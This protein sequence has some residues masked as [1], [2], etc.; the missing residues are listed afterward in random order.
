MAGTGPPWTWMVG[1]LLTALLLRVTEP[2]L[3][4]AGAACNHAPASGAS[5]GARDLGAGA[6]TREGTPLGTRENDSSSRIINGTDCP[7]HAQPWQAALLLK[8]NQLYCGAV[9]VDRQWLLT[10]AHCR[11]KIFKIRL[12]HRFLSPVYEQGQQ[13]LRGVKSIPHPGFSHPGHTNDLM[14][15]KL[16]RKVMETQNIKPIN[17]SSHCPAVGT[18][19]L[20][21]GWGTTSSPQVNFP[22]VLQCLNITVLNH[23]RCQ[24]AY[25]HQIDKTMFCAG[26]EAGRDSC[27]G[28]SGGPVICNGTL[29]GLVSWG[30]FPCAQPDKPGVYTN[31]CMFTKWIRDTIRA[32]S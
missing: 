21:S 1:A 4:N 28:D 12:G 15:V 18:S 29:Q 25:P 16:N 7:E 30:D 24:E 27:Q 17:I 23:E 6:G 31:L 13:L 8:P 14:L 19:C 32:N 2:V 26:D 22:K 20:V 3:A 5:G 10:A 11:K 9:L